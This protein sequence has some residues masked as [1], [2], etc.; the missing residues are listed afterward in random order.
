M[1]KV[2]FDIFKLFCLKWGCVIKSWMHFAK[3]KGIL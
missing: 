3:F 2:D 1:A